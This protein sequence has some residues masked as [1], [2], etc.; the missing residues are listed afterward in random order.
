MTD[1][2][3]STSW[4]CGSTAE[5]VV[6]AEASRAA[7]HNKKKNNAAPDGALGRVIDDRLPGLKLFLQI[8]VREFAVHLDYSL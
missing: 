2:T 4:S 8:I 3:V 5:D 7:Q 1:G 6:D